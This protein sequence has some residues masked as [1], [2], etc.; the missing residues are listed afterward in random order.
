MHLSAHEQERLLVH[1]AADAARRRQE[2]GH[3][4]NHPE[5]VAVLTAWVFEAARDGRSYSPDPDL[6]VG[7]F[8]RADHFAFAQAGVPGITVGPGMD[9]VDGGTAGGAADRADYFARHYHQPGDAFSDDWDMRGPVAD[10]GTMLH[11][12]RA[13]ADSSQW[14]AWQPDSEFRAEREK[15]ANARR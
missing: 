12:V 8:Y 3:R 15:T 6:S 10:T 4:L 5:A 2:R 1:V 7:L 13:V 9:Q 11:L 14:P